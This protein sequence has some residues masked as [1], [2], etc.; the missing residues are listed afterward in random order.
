MNSETVAFPADQSSTLRYVEAARLQSPAGDLAAVDVRGT[1]GQTIGSLDGVLID[2]IERRLRFFV[3]ASTT[4]RE[5]RRYL[6]PTDCAAQV[7][8]AGHALRLNLEPGN[9]TRC[10]EFTPSVVRDYSDDDLLDSLFRQR[11][12]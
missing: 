7:D 11:I 1:D 9:L 2:P 8:A 4:T 5:G 6:L 3:V 10:P 12:A